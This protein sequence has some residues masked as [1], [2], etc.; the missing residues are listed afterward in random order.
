MSAFG[1]LQSASSLG[2]ASARRDDDDATVIVTMTT[3]DPHPPAGSGL[4]IPDTTLSALELVI[5]G[6]EECTPAALQY[7]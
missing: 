4:R 3:V 6:H 7:L 5:S 2:P 1:A